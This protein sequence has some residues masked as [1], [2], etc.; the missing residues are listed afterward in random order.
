MAA[1]ADPTYTLGVSDGETRRLIAQSALIDRPT[2]RFLG[3][4]GIAPGMRVLEIGSG[5]GDVTIAA[6]RLVGPSGLVA[7]VDRN[8]AI[9]ATARRRAAEA[10]LVNLTFVEA[11]LR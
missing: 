2:R 4:A 11:D 10:G 3:D 6:A 9:L 8:G 7:G 1:R 5:A